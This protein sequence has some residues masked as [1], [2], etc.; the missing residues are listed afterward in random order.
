[1]KKQTSFVLCALLITFPIAAMAASITWEPVEN[2]TGKSQIIE[3][4]VVLVDGVWLKGKTIF[5]VA[6]D[7]KAGDVIL[8][9]NVSGSVF[10]QLQAKDTAGPRR[11][12]AKI[13]R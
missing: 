9:A 5:D 6:D 10:P 7:L 13:E 4:D 2:T 1:M 11:K 8:K 3:G 12:T